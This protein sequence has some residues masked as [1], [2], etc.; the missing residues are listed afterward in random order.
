V[1]SPRAGQGIHREGSIGA[2]K[3]L[4]FILLG[5]AFFGGLLLLSVFFIEG[6]VWVTVKLTPVI[7]WANLVAFVIAVLL[8]LPSFIRSGRGFAAICYIIVSYVFGI[9]LWMYSLIVA[10]AL[11][12][13]A[14][15]VIGLLLMGVG[16]VPV[17]I[18]AALLH[19]EWFAIG[20]LAFG[21]VLTFGTRALALF[22]A[23][24]ADHERSLA[25]IC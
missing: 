10:Y 20:N 9:T 16:V 24:K 2:L 17:A 21:L 6:A 12:G 25:L 14:G 7:E 8:I 3:N 23:S 1:Q 11:W 19:G 15:I 18:V 13:T 4:G 5:I 22:L